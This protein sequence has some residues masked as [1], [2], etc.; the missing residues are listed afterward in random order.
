MFGGEYVAPVF[1]RKLLAII[2][3]H[4]QRRVVRMQEHIWNDD[5]ALQV[6]FMPGS[7]TRVPPVHDKCDAAWERDGRCLRHQLTSWFVHRAKFET[8][9]RFTSRSISCRPTPRP[10]RQ[11]NR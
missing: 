7:C 8:K 1:C 3:R 9:R 2:K 6:E 5:F 4:L 11:S 10:S